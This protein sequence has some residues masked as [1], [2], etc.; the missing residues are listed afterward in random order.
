MNPYEFIFL[1]LGILFTGGLLVACFYY[2]YIQTKLH[3]AII[4]KIRKTERKINLID[5]D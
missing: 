3:K 1:I 5:L 4:E 2:A